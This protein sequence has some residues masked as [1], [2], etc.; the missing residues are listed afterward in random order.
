MV[1]LVPTY[2]QPLGSIIPGSTAADEG[3]VVSYFENSELTIEVTNNCSA[4]CVMCP[5]ELQTRKIE[6]MTDDVWRKTVDDAF[7]HDIKVLD[8]CGYGDVFLDKDL[9]RKLDYAKSLN[10]DFHV[11]VSTTGVAMIPRKF[12]NTLEYIDTLKF[13]IYGTTKDVYEEMMEGCDFE[14]SMSNILGYLEFQDGSSSPAYT[15]ANYI[16]MEENAHQL[17]DWI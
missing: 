8:L 17:Q 11:Y 6:R 14:K 3:Y 9:F 15:I 13:S 2:S 12:E 1:L 7:A 16:V 10:P 4:S 5:R